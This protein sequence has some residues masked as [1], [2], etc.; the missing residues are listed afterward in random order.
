MYTVHDVMT[1]EVVSVGRDSSY[2][3]IAEILLA[4]HV[5]ALPVTDGEGRVIGL[6]S[7]EDLLHKEEFSG[8]EYGPP[9]RARLRAR[10][11]SGGTARDKAAARNAGELMTS[12]A[13][14][15]APDASVARA[16]RLMERHGVK[17][18]PVVDGD[19]RL[20]G[21][22]SRRDLL[23]VFLREDEDIAAEARDE[24]T[25]ALRPVRVHGPTVAVEDGVVSLSG[26]VERR[27]EAQVLVQRLRRVEGVVAVDSALRWRVDDVVPEY[28]RWSAVDR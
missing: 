17:R 2:R 28:V 15:I 9:M 6:V 1:T 22:V 13:I 7:E 23:M 14:T 24:I 20:T 25:E 16:A 4:R 12:P 21:V 8:G 27:S 5:S 3:L 26:V 11:G 18:L 10:L 19:G